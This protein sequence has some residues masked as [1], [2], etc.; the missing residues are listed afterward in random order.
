MNFTSFAGA[1][2]GCLL[3]QCEMIIF[4]L[5]LTSLLQRMRICIFISTVIY[6]AGTDNNSSEEM[7]AQAG[8]WCHKVYRKLKETIPFNEM[9]TGNLFQ[10]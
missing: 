3:T 5:V 1:L 9:R 7:E 10:N 2:R 6:L 8:S 4:V